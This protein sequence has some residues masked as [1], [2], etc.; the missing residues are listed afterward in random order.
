MRL[1]VSGNGSGNAS[2][3]SVDRVVRD[4]QWTHVAVTYDGSNFTSNDPIFY[5]NGSSISLTQTESPAG[6]SVKDDNHPFARFRLGQMDGATTNA[7]G[8]GLYDEF[9]LWN[10]S[11]LSS[12]TISTHA[13]ASPAS[14]PTVAL[15]D[16]PDV[17][18]RLDE[19]SGLIATD[20]ANSNDGNYSSSG[21]TI[22]ETGRSG[23]AVE[24]STDGYVSLDNLTAVRNI[25]AGSGATISMW[26]KPYL[27][28]GA[29]IPSA[30]AMVSKFDELT[31]TPPGWVWSLM[32]GIEVTE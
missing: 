26:V 28:G 22:G 14:Y 31:L 3:T 7:E 23:N 6:G 25:W 19:T 4:D 32:D 20:S 2:W 16:S 17:Y 15:A 5:V 11:I 10:N 24:F 21:I 1:F 13:S 9:A 30:I 12:G 27:I 18:L 29:S 8:T